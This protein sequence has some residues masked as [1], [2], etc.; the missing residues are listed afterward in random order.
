MKLYKAIIHLIM[1]KIVVALTCAAYL[2]ISVLLP[3][4]SSL[5]YANPHSDVAVM[6]SERVKINTAEFSIVGDEHV[7]FNLTALSV[8]IYRIVGWN[9]STN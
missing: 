4:N 1:A 6:G 7:H 9:T 2:L 3:F 5:I 8:A